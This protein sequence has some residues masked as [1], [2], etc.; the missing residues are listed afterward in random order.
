[1]AKDFKEK[2]EKVCTIKDRALSL[3]DMQLNGNIENVDAKELGEVADI[4]KDMAEIMKLCAEAEYYHDITEAMDKNS[5]AENK[6]YMN[7]YLPETRY[8]GD[9]GMTPIVYANG[10]GNM[11]GMGNSGNS[12][13][14]RYYMP[15]YD[16]M[17]ERGRGYDMWDEMYPGMKGMKPHY[18]TDNGIGSNVNVS[19]PD[20]GSTH[21]TMDSGEYMRDAREGRSGIT[22]RT[23]MDM[24]E[25]GAEK[26]EKVKEIKKWA[27]DFSE[28]VMEML[29]D[30]SPEEKTTLKQHLTQLISK[31]S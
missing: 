29:E 7:Q 9:K 2:F 16:E 5:D 25:Q 13:G 17:T 12:N 24:K 18:Y 21:R 31:I 27:S 14:T 10:N 23:Y 8:Y 19:T 20:R 15:M 28:D 26:S 11:G 22:R 1:M 6:M 30:A 3:V 4:A